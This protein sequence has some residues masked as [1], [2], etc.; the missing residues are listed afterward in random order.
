VADQDHNII[1][2]ESNQAQPGPQ[3]YGNFNYQACHQPGYQAGGFAHPGQTGYRES[4]TD[5]QQQKSN[6]K[7]QEGNMNYAGYQAFYDSDHRLNDD[8]DKYF[9]YTHNYPPMHIYHPYYHHPYH[10]HSHYDHPGRYYHH[11]HGPYYGGP[12]Y[13]ARQ[14]GPYAGGYGGPNFTVN[15]PGPGW[16]NCQQANPYQG[17]AGYAMPQPNPYYGGGGYNVYQGYPYGCQ[18]MGLS[19]SIF[20]PGYL[21]YLLNTPRV[22]NFFRAVGILGV[23]L[24]LVPS[25]AR[26]FR[27]LAVSAVEGVLKV[28]EEVKNIFADAKE[29][30]DDIFAEAKWE[31]EKDEA[32]RGEKPDKA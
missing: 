19:P 11:G 2:D 8:K 26:A 10:G 9:G 13:A 5:Y 22:N 29:D 16:S 14:S 7:K 31:K 18:P 27:P 28:S 30:V 32:S 20:R 1:K 25:V 23:G 4:A 24:L 6:K 15:Q 3:G 17:G 12:N 21:S